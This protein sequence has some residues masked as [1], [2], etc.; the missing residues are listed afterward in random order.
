MQPY[1]AVSLMN[2]RYMQGGVLDQAQMLALAT[3]VWPP[4]LPLSFYISLD[5]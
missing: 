1:F 3:V 2:T 5:T 4:A